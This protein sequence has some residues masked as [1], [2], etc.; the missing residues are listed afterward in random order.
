MKIRWQDWT[1]IALGL[2][3]L[4]SPWQMGYTLHRGPAVNACGIGAAL[5]IFNLMSVWRLLDDGQEILNIMLG[6]WLMFCP[7]A[8]DFTADKGPAINTLAVGAIV[9][10]LAVWQMFDAS[11][12]GKK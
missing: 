5:V 2:W 1:S 12:A 8:L 7:V 10:A 9:I 11:K 6:V 3:L 4:A